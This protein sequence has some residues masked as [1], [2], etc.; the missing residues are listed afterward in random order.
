MSVVHLISLPYENNPSG[1]FSSTDF[2]APLDPE[3]VRASLPFSLQ[4]PIG[5][6]GSNANFLHLR[7]ITRL[8]LN[9]Q[10]S[11]EAK[12]VRSLSLKSLLFQV[13]K[14]GITYGKSLIE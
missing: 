8:F 12:S 9:G 13:S 14:D 4:K 3:I 7:F 10:I 5:E 1:V 2:P 11:I 6:Y